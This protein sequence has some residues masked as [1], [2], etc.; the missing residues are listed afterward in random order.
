MTGGASSPPGYCLTA[1]SDFTASDLPGRKEAVSFSCADSNLPA[2]A[3]PT[4][5]EIT[6]KTAKTTNFALLPAGTV[7]IRVIPEGTE[8]ARRSA[9][10]P[11][12][13]FGRRHRP[14]TREALAHVGGGAAADGLAALE[15]R[16][17]VRVAAGEHHVGAEAAAHD[18]LERLAIGP[19]QRHLAHRGDVEVDRLQ[20][21]AERLRMLGGERGQ[22][23]DGAERRLFVAVLAGERRQP[24]Q[25]E[26]GRRL[27]GGDRVVLDVLAARDQLLVVLGGREE[28]AVLRVREA[29]DDRVGERP[30]L[31][32]PARVERRLVERDQRFEQEGVVLEHRAEPRPAAVVG[33]QQ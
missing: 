30:R 31:G 4:R 1:S 15:Q 11:G 19:D 24:Q 17:A 9:Q 6:R 21:M 13:R 12:E 33:A 23:P 5:P 16:N 2:N 26:R 29:L 28:A 20:E 10:Q 18:A 3:A 27:T 7:R 14:L 32:E 22:Q 25:A 8:R